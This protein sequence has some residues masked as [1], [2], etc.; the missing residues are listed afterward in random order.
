ME[1]GQHPGSSNFGT[2]VALMVDV[3]Y[4]FYNPVSFCTIKVFSPNSLFCLTQKY[5]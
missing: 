3:L 4:S 2:S 5:K 1:G